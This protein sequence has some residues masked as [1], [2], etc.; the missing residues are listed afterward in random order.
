MPE[1]I[2]VIPDF[3]EHIKYLFDIL[4]NKR[5]N[6]SHEELPNY[7]DHTRFVK[8]HPYRKWYLVKNNSGFSG[9]IYITNSN[10]IGINL[11]SNN[12]KDYHEVITFIIDNFRPLPPIN[13]ERSKYFLVN[14]NPNNYNLIE[15]L[16]SLKMKHI[17]NTYAYNDNEKV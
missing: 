5:F 14:A 15:A 2:E 17:Q 11:I 12:S 1:L 8:H 4:K 9:S 7:K 3:E 13:S 6:I 10:V 16:E